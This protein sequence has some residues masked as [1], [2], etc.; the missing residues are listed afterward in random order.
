MRLTNPMSQASRHPRSA[1]RT[2]GHLALGVGGALET[3]GDGFSG[4]L[5]E[6]HE[7]ECVLDAVRRFE[8]L[9]SAT[10]DMARQG[11]QFSRA[12]FCS[13][14]TR[15]IERAA[16]DVRRARVPSRGKA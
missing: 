11:E 14:L 6:R 2:A 13:R 9:V 7:V 16:A 3:V 1:R 5:F 10:D 8:T 12:A 15:M 4:V